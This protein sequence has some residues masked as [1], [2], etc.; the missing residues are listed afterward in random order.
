MVNH[1]VTH[2]IARSNI[3]YN[4][5][6]VSTVSDAKSSEFDTFVS[7]AS[8]SSFSSNWVREN[9]W[10]VYEALFKMTR[11]PTN[12]LLHLSFDLA[13]KSASVLSSFVQVSAERPPRVINEDGEA[14]SFTW[15][16]GSV[17]RYL[18]VDNDSV[19][20]IER[21]ASGARVSQL[22]LGDPST[23]DFSALA[24]KLTSFRNS[25]QEDL[26]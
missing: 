4:S 11:L 8:R 23:L 22:N 15:E 19:E 5:F 1:T 21:D 7:L 2:G 16:N 10:D 24:P 3:T 17:K 12:H 26:V 6:V 14:V 13:R 20:M 9:C 25:T 18:S